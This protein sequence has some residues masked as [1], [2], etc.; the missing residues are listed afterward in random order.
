MKQ[1]GRQ[2]RMAAVRSLVTEAVVRRREVLLEHPVRVVIRD[3][4][5]PLNLSDPRPFER[6][7]RAH[8]EMVLRRPVPASCSG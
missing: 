1:T 4:A 3:Q 8:I 7:L 2:M 5:T 6:A